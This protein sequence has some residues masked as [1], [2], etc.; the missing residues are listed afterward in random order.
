MFFNPSKYVYNI[1]YGGVYINEGKNV[2]FEAFERQVRS[3]QT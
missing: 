2:D 1:Y 3:L